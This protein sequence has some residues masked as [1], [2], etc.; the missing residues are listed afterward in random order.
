MSEIAITTG[1]SVVLCARIYDHN[2]GAPLHPTAVAS[3]SYTAQRLVLTL[4]SVTRT[5]VAGHSNINVPVVPAIL[6]VPIKDEYWHT[7]ETGYNFIHEPDTRTTPLF[8]EIGTY[9]IVYTIRPVSGNPIVIPFRV[10][11]SAI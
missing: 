6:E 11:V 4:R 5:A 2:T 10:V 7:D 8:D 9:D 1:R 3:L